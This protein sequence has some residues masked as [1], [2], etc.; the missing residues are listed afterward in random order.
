MAINGPGGPTQATQIAYDPVNAATVTPDVEEPIDA[1]SDAKA[2]VLVPVAYELYIGATAAGTAAAA[3]WASHQEELGRTFNRGQQAVST[4]LNEWGKHA[5]DFINQMGGKKTD[6]G[7]SEG[8]S[9]GDDSYAGDD[10]DGMATQVTSVFNWLKDL[11]P[12]STDE[13]G[14]SN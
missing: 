9:A 14:D 1:G 8:D 3:Y 13:G 7:D 10:V 6:T 11:L 2:A 5:K 4:T 12:T